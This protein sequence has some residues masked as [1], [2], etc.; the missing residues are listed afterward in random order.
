MYEF[1]LPLYLT[2]LSTLRIA[3]ECGH[4]QMVKHMLS[5]AGVKDEESPDGMTSLLLAIGCLDYEL[6]GLLAT[7]EISRVS[8]ELLCDII[9]ELN[10]AITAEKSES[11]KSNMIKLRET[12]L[13]SDI[14]KQCTSQKHGHF[15]SSLSNDEM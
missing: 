1:N 9:G 8:P 3:C 13:C 11:K 5:V 4:V 6:T 7:P 12:I 10:Q 2:G 15:T 14:H